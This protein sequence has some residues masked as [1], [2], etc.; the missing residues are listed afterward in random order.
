MQTMSHNEHQLTFEP[1]EFRGSRFRCL[2]ATSLPKPKFVEWMNSLIQP[3]A[4]VTV[5]DKYMPEGFFQPDE[6]KLGETK[7][8]LD[9]DQRQ[10]VTRW[11]LAVRRNANTPNWDFVSTCKVGEREGLVLLEAKAHAGELK[12]DDCCGARNQEN[13]ERISQAIGEASRAL[14][15]GWSLRA[16]RCYQ[17]SNR[18]AWSW[19]IAS[20]GKP[21][22]LV[23]LGFRNA[24][25]MQERFQDDAAWEH[26][27]LEYADGC[28]P[29]TAW[30]SRIMVN[31]T[32]LIPLIRTADINV[33]AT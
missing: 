22:V 8:F 3:F 25:E 4:E 30:N 20:L 10:T 15:S 26:S 7:G 14:G 17:L 31:G 13:R 21:V 16:D 6:A 29:G 9:G 18:F 27:L 11:W 2:L 5:G 28:V 1:R 12:P 24:H 33:I 32:P 23:Y 19:K